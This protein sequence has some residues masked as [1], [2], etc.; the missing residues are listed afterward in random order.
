MTWFGDKQPRDVEVYSM[1]GDRLANT[2]LRK[3]SAMIVKKKAVPYRTS[4][5]AIKMLI[6]TGETGKFTKPVKEEGC[7]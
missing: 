5:F 1:R 3:A 6:P 7:V 4:P 2:T